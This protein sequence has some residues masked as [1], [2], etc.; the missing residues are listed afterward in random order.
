MVEETLAAQRIKLAPGRA[1]RIEPAVKA[2]IDAVQSETP[3][4][5][6]DADA[7]GHAVAMERCK[8]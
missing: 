2:T 7:T 5:D 1:E 3:K 4:L 8:A 6:F